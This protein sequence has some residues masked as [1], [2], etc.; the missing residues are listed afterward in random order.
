MSSGPMVISTFQVL[1]AATD[2]LDDELGNREEALEGDTEI[3][4]AEHAVTAGREK[5]GQ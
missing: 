1:I 4:G 3:L 5:G 2:C